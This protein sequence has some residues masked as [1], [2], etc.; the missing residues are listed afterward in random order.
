MFKCY[1]STVSK[2]E[3]SGYPVFTAI[4]IFDHNFSLS[5][6]YKVQIQPQNVNRK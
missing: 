1:L 6:N 3:N 4:L 2:F 5:Q